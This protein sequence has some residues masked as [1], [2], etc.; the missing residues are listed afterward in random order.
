MERW[1]II[2]YLIW[3][4]LSHL[5]KVKF[6]CNWNALWLLHLML[7]RNW[8]NSETNFVS[9]FSIS[10]A[11]TTLKAFCHDS[12]VVPLLIWLKV[13]SLCNQFTGLLGQVGIDVN[14]INSRIAASS[15][16]VWNHHLFVFLYHSRNVIKHIETTVSTSVPLVYWKKNAP[17][18]AHTTNSRSHRFLCKSMCFQSSIWRWS[19]NILDIRNL[20]IDC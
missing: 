16:L 17:F 14:V 5:T 20:S 7:S 4:L 8:H 6:L 1:Y 10:L 11:K 3:V 12:R 19:G 18:R 9:Q 15:M 13:N 2:K